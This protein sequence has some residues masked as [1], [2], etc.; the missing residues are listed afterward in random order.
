MVTLWGNIPYTQALDIDNIQPKY[1][2]AM[3][4]YKDLLVRLDTDI[5]GLSTGG[6]E[7]FGGADLV[8]HGDVPSWIMFANSLKLK[9]GTILSD[10]DPTLAATTINSAIT[11]GVFSSNADN[12]EFYFL[13][14]TPNTNPL[15]VDL[16]LSGRQDFIGTTIVTEYMNPYLDPR[17]TKYFNGLAFAYD[18]NDDGNPIDTNLDGEG[19]MLLIYRDAKDENDSLVRV[20]LP[21]MVYA[22]DASNPFTY[23]LGGV[24]GA[25][26]PYTDFSHVGDMLSKD[27]EF[28][29]L[30]L[31]YVEVNFYLAEAV[32]RTFVSGNAEE[33]YK[34]GI[35]ASFNY[36]GIVDEEGT[37]DS[38]ISTYINSSDVAFKATYEEQM[39][40]I[41][42]QSW[43]GFYNN[44]YLGWT[45]YRRFGF[46]TMPLAVDATISEIPSR[47]TYP[48]FEQTLNPANYAEA[49]AAIGGDLLTTKL[50]FDKH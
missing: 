31:S 33:Y 6:T 1:D 16:T 26:N 7:S 43:L 50:F 11:G 13:S 47:F 37:T 39:V 19:N 12:A 38:I 28:P 29:C 41:A 14:A 21:H 34:D 5:A 24:Y 49:S 9:M 30:L 8:Y 2:D 48:V 35:E 45:V 46:P 20:E 25:S 3:T 15:Y 42:T 27:P 32:T 18:L 4:I 44:G 10:V 17:M 23:N 40:Q 22:A 36:W